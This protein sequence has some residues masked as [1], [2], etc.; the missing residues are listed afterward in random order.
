MDEALEYVLHCV[1]SGRSYQKKTLINYGCVEKALTDYHRGL[2]SE[3]VKRIKANPNTNFPI[4]LVGDMKVVIAN[5]V[6]ENIDVFAVT[7]PKDH[8]EYIKFENKLKTFLVALF[9]FFVY[10]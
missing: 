6:F 3:L 8:V 9:K 10:S 4:T 7:L 5:V 2:I 1:V